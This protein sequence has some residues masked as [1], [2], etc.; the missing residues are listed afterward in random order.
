V[1]ADYPFTLSTL[2]SKLKGQDM[3]TLFSIGCAGDINHINVSSAEPQKGHAEAARIG[4]I[5]AGEVVKSYA[6]LEPVQT[7]SPTARREVLEL[8][9]API[10]PEHV[11]Q[12]RQ[13]A[14]KFG[15]DAPTFLERVHAYK[16]LD[17]HARQGK[18]LE[19]EVQVMALGPDVAFVALPGEIF[20]ELGLYVKKHSPYR[21][22]IVAELANGSVGYVPTKRAYEEGNYEAVSA[23][24]AAGS[25]ERIAEAAVRLLKAL[26]EG[27]K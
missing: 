6:R 25:G 21:H 20:V 16:V 19:A 8:A 3:V 7:A 22:T 26:K 12:A 24:C 9:L 15:K 5:L 10:D 11:A 17:V 2:L 27:T 23:R 18:P 1:S 14:V 4:T 13:I